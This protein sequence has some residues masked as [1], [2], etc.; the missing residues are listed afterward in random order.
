MYTEVPSK[1]TYIKVLSKTMYTDF[2]SK[3]CVNAL[4]NGTYTIQQ[5]VFCSYFSVVGNLWQ[6]QLPVYVFN[7]GMKIKEVSAKDLERTAGAKLEL[8]VK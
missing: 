6:I 8:F 2:P 7:S 1:S 3:F 4:S 5:Y